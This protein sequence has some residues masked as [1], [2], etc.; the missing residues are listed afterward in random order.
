MA[1]NDNTSAIIDTILKFLLGG[2]AIATI[3]VLPNSAQIFAKPLEKYFDKLDKRSQQRELRRVLRYMKNQGLVKLSSE[4]YE[5]G[6]TITKTGLKRLK[7]SDFKNIQIPQPQIWDKQ[8]RIVLFDIPERLR[9]ERILLTNKLKQ[10]GFKPLQQ[11]AWIYPFPC[12]KEVEVV[13]SNYELSRYV[14][15]IETRHIDNDK[16]LRQR[17]SSVLPRK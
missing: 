16:P 11:S 13:T 1:K 7:K 6:L 2:G 5:H 17:F 4:D 9:G 15:Y 3:L 8:W 10:L 14:S 12:R